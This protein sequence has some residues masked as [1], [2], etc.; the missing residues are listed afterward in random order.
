MITITLEPEKYLTLMD[1]LAIA[2]K[3]QNILSEP[4]DKEYDDKFK[5]LMD[6]IDFFAD[7]LNQEKG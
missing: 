1:G 6:E 2:D 5:K 7:N 3:V 4:N